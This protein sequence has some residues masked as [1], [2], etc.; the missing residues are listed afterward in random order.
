MSVF[1]I[2]RAIAPLIDIA[3]YTRH[4][5]PDAP[6]EQ[7]RAWHVPQDCTRIEQC[8]L[9]APGE[10][11]GALRV[12]AFHGAKRALIRSSQRTWDTGGIFDLDVFSKDVRAVYRR[13]QHD[14]GWTGF[15]DPVDYVEGEFDVTQVCAIGPDGLILAIIEPHYISSVPLPP[16]EALS[17][18][19]NST[20]IVRD[21]DVAKAFYCDTLDWKET[22]AFDITDSVEPGV[23]VLGLPM[24]YA[25]Q[26]T[27]R[28][29]IVHPLGLNDGSVELIQNVEMHGRDFADKAVAPNVG[30]L[31]L[32]FPIADANA[33]ANEI[34][35][36][37]AELYT[38]PM[39]LTL[40]PYGDA[41]LF[42]IRSPDGAILEFYELLRGKT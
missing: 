15:G 21:Y 22:T 9:T 18:V 3:G 10:T 6:P 17:R 19:F 29:G 23:S 5:L 20:Q 14:H 42:S 37:G 27:R 31:T 24:P 13:L 2:G 25:K 1:D 26:S 35:A 32:R 36:R 34:V 8:L 39:G 33:Y 30:L 7:F 12:V 40:T 4:A 38:E 11:R 41:L 28:I 16:F